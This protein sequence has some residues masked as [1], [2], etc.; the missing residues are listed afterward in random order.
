MI[1]SQTDSLAQTPPKM[2]S[3]KPVTSASLIWVV[4]PNLENFI[5]STIWEIQITITHLN[6]LPPL[7]KKPRSW[8]VV[9]N[10]SM[11]WGTNS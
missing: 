4:T 2:A 1:W 10:N 8:D 3:G 6:S 5:P 7:A 11:S 9:V